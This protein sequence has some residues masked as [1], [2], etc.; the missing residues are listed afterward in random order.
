MIVRAGPPSVHALALAG[1]GV[2]LLATA[3]AFPLDAPPFSLLVC[4]FKLATGLPCLGCG[5]TRAFHFAVRGELAPAFSAS[6]LGA[7]LAFACATHAVWTSLRVAGLSYAPALRLGVVARSACGVLLA[8][9]W[10]YLALR[11]AG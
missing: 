6:P 4:P 1:V 5:C 8:A 11:S 7:M 9:N 2:L 10:L 3:V